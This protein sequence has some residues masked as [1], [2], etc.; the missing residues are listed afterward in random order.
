VKAVEPAERSGVVSAARSGAAS[1]VGRPERA[2]I[3]SVLLALTDADNPRL[4]LKHASALAQL[5]DVE[6]HVLRVLPRTRPLLGKLGANID[7]VHVTRQVERCLAA[8]RATKTFCDGVL[9]EPISARRLR[10]RIGDFIEEVACHARELPNALIL[11][12]PSTGRLGAT[13]T[14]LARASARSVLVVRPAPPQSTR[15][16]ATHPKDEDV[17]VLRQAR[18]L[19]AQMGASVVALHNASCASRELG[20]RWTSAF[21]N[22]ASRAVSLLPEAR[23]ALVA[24]RLAPLATLS[25]TEIDPVDAIIEQARLHRAYIIVVGTRVRS[26]PRRFVESSVALEVIHRADRSVLVVPRLAS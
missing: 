23:L 12:A 10:I 15:I 24:Q 17:W 11:L 3:S 1:L 22:R 8:A 13:A 21:A 7:L 2:G 4:A 18:S 20:V 14:A 25:T 26:C 19:A 16:A 6:L 5:L 9:S